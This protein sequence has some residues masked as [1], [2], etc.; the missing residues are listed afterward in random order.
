VYDASRFKVLQASTSNP[1]T[2]VF[3]RIIF[4]DQVHHAGYDVSVLLLN[5]ESRHGPHYGSI[6]AMFNV[7]DENNFEFV[8]FR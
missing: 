3:C 4:P 5:R 2:N 6:G 8:L 1:A 7:K